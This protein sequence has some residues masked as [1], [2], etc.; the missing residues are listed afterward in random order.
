MCR[1]VNI[2]NRGY[3]FKKTWLRVWRKQYLEAMC[4]RVHVCVQ[5]GLETLNA[6]GKN[7]VEG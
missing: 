7:P 5:L 3:S 4:V 2:E 6:D 1:K